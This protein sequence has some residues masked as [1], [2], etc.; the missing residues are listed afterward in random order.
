[1]K[2]KENNGDENEETS[3]ILT[4]L[5]DTQIDIQQAE[6]PQPLKWWETI[7]GKG[8][9]LSYILFQKVNRH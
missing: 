4:P 3:D 5:Q 8:A 1:M 6:K 9:F 2:E 7:Q